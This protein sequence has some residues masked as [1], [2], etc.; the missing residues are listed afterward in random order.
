MISL[1]IYFIHSI[2]RHM[3]Q[4]QFPN[5]SRSLSPLVSIYLF[6]LH[7][8]I[9][10]ILLKEWKVKSE[11]HSVWLSNRSLPDCR[12][13]LYQL[14]HQESPGIL[15][16]VAYSFSGSS[17][18]RKSNQSLLHCRQILYHWATGEALD[19]RNRLS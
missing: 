10:I 9:K 15:E 16:C 13:I 18:P 3:C 12:Q 17:W 7:L 11:S 8:W 5:S 2:N 1:V 6:S 4:F 19:L 14:S